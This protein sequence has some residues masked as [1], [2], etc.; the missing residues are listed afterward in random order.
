MTKTIMTTDYQQS[1]AE[2]LVEYI[3][4]DRATLRDPAG[5]EMGAAQRERFVAKSERHEFERSVVVSPGNADELNAEDIGRSTRRTMSAI[6]G[7]R[8]T[9]VCCYAVY[10]DTE[11]PHAH[12]ALTGAKADLYMDTDD[13]REH[14]HAREN[15]YE[16]EGRGVRR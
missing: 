13:I 5:L 2:A 10:T 15:E 8:P 16:I 6:T 1:D 14:E 12:V 11:N 7:D 3:G 9:A 4:R